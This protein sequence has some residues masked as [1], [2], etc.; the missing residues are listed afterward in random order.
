MG[1]E[2][3]TL[4]GVVRVVGFNTA[5]AGSEFE[6]LPAYGVRSLVTPEVEL[7]TVVGTAYPAWKVSDFVQ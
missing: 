4:C 1:G 7:V 3:K 6:V 2:R 5:A